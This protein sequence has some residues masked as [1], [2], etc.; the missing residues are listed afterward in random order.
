MFVSAV[1]EWR[2]GLFF[3]EGGD[4]QRSFWVFRIR[5]DLGFGRFIGRKE[6]CTTSQE[7]A[8]GPSSVNSMHES[9][10]EHT[11]L[12]LIFFFF[13]HLLILRCQGLF[14]QLRRI[15]V[16]TPSS[17]PHPQPMI[18]SILYIYVLRIASSSIMLYNNRNMRS[19]LISL[20][21]PVF[22]AVKEHSQDALN[23]DLRGRGVADRSCCCPLEFLE[24]Q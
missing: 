19:S 9:L 22:L 16:R 8:A 17:S 20:L 23:S 6:R 21:A 15:P 10:S 4:P 13:L 24:I 5:R 7:I 3:S 1:A 12:E 18:P 14:E 11:I 2:R